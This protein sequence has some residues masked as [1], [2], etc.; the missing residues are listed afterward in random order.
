MARKKLFYYPGAK[1]LVVND[2]IANFPPNY[3]ELNWLE[4]YGGSGIVTYHKNPSL[5]EIF[6]DLDEGISAIFYCLLFKFEEFCFRLSLAQHS[7]SILNWIVDDDGSDDSIVDKAVKKMYLMQH[8]FSSKG[9][10]ISFYKKYTSKRLETAMN[11]LDINLMNR[12]R[13]RFKK[14][15]I[16]NRDAIDV[17]KQFDSPNLFIYVDPP[18]TVTEKGNHYSL[19][20]TVEDH[21]KLADCLINMKG[22]WLLS[23]DD[24]PL[25]HELYKGFDQKILTVPYMFKRKDP[26]AIRNKDELLIANYP[27]IHQTVLTDFSLGN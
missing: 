1:S 13:A 27:L 11:L 8:S 16:L 26:T 20:Y 14:V 15:Q 18:Y 17:I 5:I 7:E 3:S 12:W 21:Q 23:Y 25:I 9:T 10:H 19:N 22:K 6:N 2:I 4:P 24:N